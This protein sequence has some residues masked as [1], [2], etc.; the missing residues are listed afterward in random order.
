[1]RVGVKIL[2]C[3]FILFLATVF[4]LPE[5]AYS[6]ERIKREYAIKAAFIFNF[7]KFVTWPEPY[8][9]QENLNFCILGKDPFG[10]KVLSQFEGKR[11]KGK[12]FRIKKIKHLS[13]VRRCQMLYVSTSERHRLRWILTVVNRM[14]VPVLT[15]GDSDRFIKYGGMINLYKYKNK[16]RFEINNEAAR[17]KGLKISSKLLRLARPRE[18]R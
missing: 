17:V 4:C 3:F 16:I 6:A 10:E 12:V 13:S 18:A 5:T 11:V 15:V 1:M 8:N 7:A 9:R 14:D 2:R